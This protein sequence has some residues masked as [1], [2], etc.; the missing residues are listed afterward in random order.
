M[1][2]WDVATCSLLVRRARRSHAGVHPRRGHRVAQAR[3]NLLQPEPRP[4]RAA[5]GDRRLRVAAARPH[6]AERHRRHQLRHVGA[7]DRRRRRWSAG[8]PGG[9]GDAA[10]AQPGGDSEDP[11]GATSYCVPLDFAILAAEGMDARSRSPARGAH[12][13]HTRLLLLNSPNNPT[14]WTIDRGAQR[15]ILEHCRRHGIWLVADD[16]YERLYYVATAAPAAPSFL[17]IA[18]ADDRVV[19][20]NT[21][22]K[23]W[24]HD[25]LAA[26]LDRR[27]RPLIA[28]SPS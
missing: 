2:E 18:D 25:R 6:G 4:A 12:A 7:D 22:S 14:G 9:R 8:R 26:G 1:R 27:A 17:D 10:V 15:A 13:G 28:R 16:V 19:S 3:R 11:R 23:S 20:T 24:L 21:F 5:R